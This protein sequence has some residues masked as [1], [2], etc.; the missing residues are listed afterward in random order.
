MKNNLPQRWIDKLKI[1]DI[2]FQPIVNIHTGEIYA[3]E[4]LLRNYQEVGFKSIFALFDKVDEEN[5]LYIFDIELRRKAIEK[6]TS[7]NNFKYIKLF[8]NLEL[9]NLF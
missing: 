5:I 9:K 3:V 4:A 7:I 2:A 6:F 8:Y 1:L